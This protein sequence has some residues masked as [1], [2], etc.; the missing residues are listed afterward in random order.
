MEPVQTSVFEVQGL[1]CRSCIP[2][3]NLA[4]RKLEGI[5]DVEVWLRDGKVVVEHSLT[6]TEPEAILNA[7]RGAGF[8]T[9]R[10]AQ[11]PR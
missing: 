7:I 4:V 2:R 8:E 10:L 6:R 11:T 5:E 1:T 3:L 9:R